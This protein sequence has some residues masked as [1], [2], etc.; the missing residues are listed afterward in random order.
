MREDAESKFDPLKPEEFA[1]GE[2]R[3]SFSF[4]GL[5]Q[6][7]NREVKDLAS[8]H[9]FEMCM[10]CTAC[11]LCLALVSRFVQRGRL[12]SLT[13]QGLEGHRSNREPPCGAYYAHSRGLVHRSF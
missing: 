11:E 6:A 5:F 7:S 8:G 3:S 2:P 12:T 1:V 10:R 9:D 13:L 4:R